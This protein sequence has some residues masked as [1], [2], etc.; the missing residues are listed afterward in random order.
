MTERVK[1]QLLVAL[2]LIAGAVYFYERSSTSATPS[3][4]SADTR[5]V[6]L[7][8]KE[9][10]LQVGRLQQLQ[11]DEYAG[12]K[13]NIFLAGAVVPPPGA[14]AHVSE[15]PRPFVG[16]EKPPPPPPLQVPVEFYGVESSNGRQVAFF[17]NGDDIIPAAE[18]DTI[19]KRFKLIRIGNQSAEFE[20]VSTG[21]H[22]TLPLVQS[23]DQS[24]S[25]G[26]PSPSS[27]APSSPS[28]GGSPAPLGGGSPSPF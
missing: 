13:R 21:R 23:T 20:E 4:L 7:G 19:L 1:A 17:K 22:A 6:P 15:A 27:A 9:P 12:A 25:G 2:L 28:S 24:G 18:G 14:A 11:K 5:F 3:V 8:V 26:S 16:P 10:A